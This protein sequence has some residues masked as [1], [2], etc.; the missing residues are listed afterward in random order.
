M[1]PKHQANPGKG[2][3][4]GMANA[5]VERGSCCWFVDC[6]KKA[7]VATTPIEASGRPA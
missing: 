3:L 7:A 2:S 1:I 5:M 4:D 6:G